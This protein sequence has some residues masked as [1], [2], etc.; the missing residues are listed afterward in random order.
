VDRFQTVD[1]TAQILRKGLVSAEHCGE[2]RVAALNGQLLSVQQR[3]EAR[4]PQV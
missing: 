3:A 1:P 2:Q 4:F